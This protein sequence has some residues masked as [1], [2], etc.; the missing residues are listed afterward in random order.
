MRSRAGTPSGTA[1]GRVVVG[2]DGSE[3]ALTALRWA[4]DEARLRS[5]PLEVVHAWSY[6]SAAGQ[7][8]VPYD[9]MHRAA[10]GLLS[11]AVAALGGTGSVAIT[12]TL[13]QGPAAEVLLRAAEGAALL[14]VGTRGRGGF[15][16]LLLGSVSQ[17]VAQRAACPVTIVPA[18]QAPA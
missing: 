17:H 8:Y 5:A 13:A 6:V 16:G 10:R 7:Q 18:R 14:V 9:V 2:V 11:A 1:A 15:A 12:E 4:L 3:G